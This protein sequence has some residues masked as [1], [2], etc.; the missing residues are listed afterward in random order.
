MTPPAAGGLAA[1]FRSSGVIALALA[2]FFLF[3]AVPARA[4]TGGRHVIVD[5]DMAADDARALALL[6]A[7]PYFQV[8]A[9]VTSDGVSPPDLGA[10]NVCRMLRFLKVDGVAVGVGRT[11]D[12]PPPPF[13]TNATGLDW[14]QLGEP[15]IPPMGLQPAASLVQLMLRVAPQRVIYLCLG[16]LTNLAEALDARPELAEQIEVVIWAGTPTN[17]AQPGWNA[18]RDREAVKKIAAAGLRVEAVHWPDDAAAPVFDEA[19]LA[20]L[21]A[22]DS[23]VAKL[24]VLL[25]STGRGGE[26][27][28]A[29]H[30]RLWDD[31]V[32]L[33]LGQASLVTAAP[34][35]GQPNWE[36]L[37]PLNADAVRSALTATL[38]LL[39]VR[40]TV[41]LGE[42][43]TN[44]ERLMSDVREIAPEIIARHGLEEWKAAVLT[45]ELHRHLG[46][47][48]I[49]GAKMGLR[50]RE[51]F[52]VALDE[53]HVESHAGLKPPLSCVNDGLQVATGASLGRGTISVL[54]NTPLVCEA[55][56]TYG[57]RRLR[58]RLKP[59]FAQRIAAD[60]AEL[61]K[62]H[63]GTPPAY[64]EDVRGV[65]LKHWLNFDRHTMFEET[66]TRATESK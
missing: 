25:H 12:A 4:H 41:V 38:R 37:T 23:P 48:S 21:R 33:R 1:R 39:P 55:V 46:T 56:F 13:R 2:M 66:E 28:R 32:A 7:S 35:N 16:P 3:A 50:A 27:V 60:M 40:A 19:L 64:F 26:L 10:T 24:I 54:T 29:K 11:L 47:Y 58:L 36:D 59:E 51:Y 22:V 65:S 45:S 52:N 18:R 6:L 5:T 14:A 34:I 15:A 61:V 8:V 62:R 44:P 43:P 42:F 20:E 30:L 53:L 49:V 57:D 9:V 17:A 63:G 31:L